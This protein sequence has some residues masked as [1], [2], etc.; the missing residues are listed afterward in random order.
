MHAIIDNFSRR[1]LAW[2]V[3]P[4]FDTGATAKLI[5]EAAMGI[6]GKADHAAPQVYM[7]SG[8]EN[9]NAHVTALI[10][11]NTI[12][13]VLAQVDIHFSNSMIESWWRQ[14]KH[15]WLFLNTLDS[16]A[17]VRKLVEFYVQ[18][19]ASIVRFEPSTS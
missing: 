6:K 5:V 11:A 16:I 15:Q 8:V 14:L 9:I 17:T 1:I 4:T 12:Q 18:Q 10:E 7:D 19:R 3:D 2:C 13:R